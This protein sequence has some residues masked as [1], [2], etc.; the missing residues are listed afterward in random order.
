M[1]KTIDSLLKESYRPKPTRRVYI[2][3]A[4]GKMRPLGIS[5]P[6]DKIIQQAMKLVL[7]V[8]L[9][10]KFLDSSHGFR[11]K[12]GCHTALSEIRKWKGSADL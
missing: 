1:D 7:E 3:K 10:P 2:P 6:R 9:E 5:S 4:N 12:R 11:P 8:V